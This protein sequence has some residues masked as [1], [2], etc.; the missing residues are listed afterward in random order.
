M[1][2]LK[3]R[4]INTVGYMDT[5]ISMAGW[6][7]AYMAKRL[8]IRAVLY[9]PAYKH[10]LKHNQELHLAKWEQFKAV[11]QPLNNPSIHA[12]NINMARRI[13]QN[14]YPNGQWLPN[15]LK[16]TETIGAV[17]KEAATA[18]TTVSPKTIVICVGSGVMTAGVLQG[19][20]QAKL[21]YKPQVFAVLAHKAMDPVKKQQEILNLAGFS[22]QNTLIDTPLS[23][24][25]SSFSVIPGAYDYYTPVTDIKAPFPSCP[26]Y[27]LKAY[28]YLL[29]NFDNFIPPIL[30]WNIGAKGV[31]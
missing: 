29:E 7:I 24:I 13:F 14:R 8:G 31:A 28:Q 12:I 11:I 26:Y 21:P 25:V 27:D 18:M 23:T 6:G 19:I 22:T 1:R 5:S 20:Q 3:D 4:G 15:G 2:N 17:C 9:Y 10:G 30:F 16:F